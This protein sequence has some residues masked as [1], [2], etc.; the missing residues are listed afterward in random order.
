MSTF[1]FTKAAINESV[2]LNKYK[3]EEESC[4]TVTKTAESECWV[5]K[6]TET[7]CCDCGEAEAFIGASILASQK[8]RKYASVL[9]MLD[10]MIPC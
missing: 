10:E 5:L 7:Y 8:I 1:S 4:A 2:L 6:V 3:G 9:V